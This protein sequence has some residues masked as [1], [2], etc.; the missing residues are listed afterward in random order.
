[1]RGLRGLRWHRA[2][3]AVL[4]ARQ[5]HNAPSVARRIVFVGL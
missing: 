1:M 3:Q 5:K 4:G 2:A